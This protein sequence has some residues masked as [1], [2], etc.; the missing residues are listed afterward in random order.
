M[1]KRQQ[2]SQILKSQSHSSQRGHALFMGKL[3]RR[4]RCCVKFELQFKDKSW[5]WGRSWQQ[6]DGFMEAVR[7][8]QLLCGGC[9]VCCTE[10][11]DIYCK[12][13]NSIS[14]FGAQEKTWGLGS[15]D[16]TWKTFSAQII[17]PY[18]GVSLPP[19]QK[20]NYI[21]SCSTQNK[22]VWWKKISMYG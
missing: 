10:L 6:C 21:Y 15:F 11:N 16:F 14:V 22:M 19:R 13:H 9:H 7:L 20:E 17:V 8:T 3:L 12:F 5:K 4:S 18:G 1:G 2:L